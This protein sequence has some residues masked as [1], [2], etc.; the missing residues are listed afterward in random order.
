VPKIGSCAPLGEGELGPHLSQCDQS[1]GPPPYQVTSC[2]PV[3]GAGSPSDTMWPVPRPTSV[4][5][6]IMICLRT[7]GNNRHKPKIGGCVPF[8]GRGE[9]GLHL[10]QC[11][12]G[13]GLSPIQVA[14]WSIQPFGHNT[15]TLLRDRQ[16]DRQTTVR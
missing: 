10:T 5:S 7:F 11:G 6:G 16:T 9:L 14:F 2:A 15:P 4:P 8:G 1:R 3:G 13:R 12:L